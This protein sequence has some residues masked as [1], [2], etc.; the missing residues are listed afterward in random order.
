MSSIFSGCK[1]LRLEGNILPRQEADVDQEHIDQTETLFA[2]RAQSGAQGH[3]SAGA[4]RF[5]PA[6]E[7]DFV[8][9]IGSSLKPRR[10]PSL[11]YGRTELCRTRHRHPLLRPSLSSCAGKVGS[12]MTRMIAVGA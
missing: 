10:L 4:P 9:L 8:R 5:P 7:Q 2:M 12:W 1:T 6:Q 3:R 11:D